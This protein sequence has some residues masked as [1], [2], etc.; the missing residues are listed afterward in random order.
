LKKND[1]QYPKLKYMKL[2]KVKSRINWF[3]NTYLILAALL[4]VFAISGCDILDDG[5][6]SEPSK[7]ELISKTWKVRKVEINSVLSNGY[8]AYQLNFNNNGTYNFQTT[9]STSGSW[10]LNSNESA[11]ILDKGTA[12][13]L[14]MNIIKLSLEELDIE[15]TEPATFK[16]PQKNFKWYLIQ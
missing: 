13:E 2:D 7:I 3:G 4:I 16:D 10:E 6:D 5:G 11:I 12:N 15:Y 14:I 8:E 1:G 9:S